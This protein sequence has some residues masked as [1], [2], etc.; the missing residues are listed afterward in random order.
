MIHEPNR[1]SSPA[2]S[3]RSNERAALE[4]PTR[5]RDAQEQTHQHS[6]DGH[7]QPEMRRVKPELH[8]PE[9]LLNFGRNQQHLVLAML[10]RFIE[11]YR[12]ASVRKCR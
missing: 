11:N 1:G 7:F 8:Q 6:D 3:S 12:S 4:G 10:L 2:V 5:Y 9:R